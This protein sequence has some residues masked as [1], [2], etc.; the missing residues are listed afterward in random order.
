MAVLSRYSV[1]VENVALGLPQGYTF[2]YTIIY[3]L[4]ENLDLSTKWL[5]VTPRMVLWLGTNQ[6][7]IIAYSQCNALYRY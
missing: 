6:T 5:T 4:E 2:D 3:A 7:R 1:C